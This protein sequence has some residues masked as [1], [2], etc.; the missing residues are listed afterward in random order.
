MKITFGKYKGQD[1]SDVP[2]SYLEWGVNNLSSANWVNA[3]E[4]ELKKRRKEE[5]SRLERWKSSI[6]SPEVF[7]EIRGLELASIRAEIQASGCEWEYINYDEEK[8]ADE[9]AEQKVREI[10][11]EIRKDEILQSAKQWAHSRGVTNPAHTQKMV[12]AIKSY[13]IFNLTELKDNTTEKDVAIAFKEYL[14]QIPAHCLCD[15]RPAIA[16]ISKPESY[17][18]IVNFAREYHQV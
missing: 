12:D 11:D 15:F 7:S 18:A 10:K 3:F 8:A 14:K 16:Q 17:E 5:S 4:N 6:D 2:T 13:D 1:V 9:L